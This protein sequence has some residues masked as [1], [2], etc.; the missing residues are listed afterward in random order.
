MYK[1]MVEM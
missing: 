1:D